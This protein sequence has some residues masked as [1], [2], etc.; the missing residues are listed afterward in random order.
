MPVQSCTCKTMPAHAVMHDDL[1]YKKVSLIQHIH[2][3]NIFTYPIYSVIQH[4]SGPLWSDKWHSTALR[5]LYIITISWQP[6][7]SSRSTGRLRQCI[8][9]KSGQFLWS[10]KSNRGQTYVQVMWQLRREVC[11]N[12]HI[13]RTEFYCGEH[14]RN[15]SCPKGQTFSFGWVLLRPNTY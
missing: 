1:T 11:G 8:P 6:A 13:V 7:H 3:F 12:A 4:E 14:V 2:L 15:L 10:A 5:E 9:T